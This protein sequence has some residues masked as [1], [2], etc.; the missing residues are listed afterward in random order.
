MNS[1]RI[2]NVNDQP[3]ISEKRSNRNT[4]MFMGSNDGKG[5][6]MNHLHG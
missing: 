4:A 1:G 3:I 6:D 2:I 5:W